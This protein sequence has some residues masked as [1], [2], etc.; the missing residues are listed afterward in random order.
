VTDAYAVTAA[1]C[2]ACL[3]WSLAHKLARPR[4]SPHARMALYLEVTSSRLG[5]PPSPR[6]VPVVPWEA[7]RRVLGP[8][9]SSF[10]SLV[11]RL[12]GAGRAEPLEVALRN[13]GSGLGVQ[14]YRRASVRWA[15]SAPLALGALGALTGKTLYVVVFFLAGLF[16]GVRRMPETLKSATRRR[17]EQIRSDLATVACVLAVKIENNKSLVAAVEDL[18]PEGSGPV[19]D[20]LQRALN[21]I[22]ANYGERAAFELLAYEAAEPSAARFYR[23]LAAATAGGL[24]LAK[25]L[26]DQASE[27]RAQRREE[28]ERTA[29]RRQMAL[30][31][32]N[33]LFMAPVLFA[34]LLAPL[35]GLLFGK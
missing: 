27:L 23:F 32:P 22:N 1:L 16:A 8:P 28:V 21:L 24:D 34:F 9:G 5:A 10:I 19:I 6:T 35:P 29:S 26:L 17:N 11:L 30:V 7:V 14:G 3:V 15:V 31:V 33:L 20:D 12:L 25:A 2:A 4:R 13:A 18:V